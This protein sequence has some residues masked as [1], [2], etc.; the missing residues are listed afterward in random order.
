[1]CNCAVIP[2][3]YFAKEHFAKEPGYELIFTMLWVGRNIEICLS[4]ARVPLLLII[5]F[6]LCVEEGI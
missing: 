3:G 5:F 4:K 1:M 2:G 6:L